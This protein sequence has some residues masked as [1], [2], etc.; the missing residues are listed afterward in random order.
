MN[1]QESMCVSSDYLH[2]VDLAEST[3]NYES[4]ETPDGRSNVVQMQ[5]SS[6]YDEPHP[7]VVSP[8]FLQPHQTLTTA[9]TDRGM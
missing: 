8:V 6:S 3:S 9:F 7:R 2:V 4:E 1:E 5:P